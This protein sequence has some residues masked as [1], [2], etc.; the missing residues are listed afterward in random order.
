MPAVP[1]FRASSPDRQSYLPVRV[2]LETTNDDDESQ[3][4]SDTTVY[5]QAGK[6]L[7]FAE[8][9]FRID[10]VHDPLPHVADGRLQIVCVDPT[11]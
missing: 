11:K 10:V 3:D 6:L 8:R 1:Q 2:G 9:T 7:T 4:I 5:P